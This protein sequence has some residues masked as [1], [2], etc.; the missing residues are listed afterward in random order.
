M[1]Q[2]G[3]D[4]FFNIQLQCKLCTTNTMRN[5]KRL[6][7]KQLISTR[8][9]LKYIH[10]LKEASA[11]GGE[12]AASICKRRRVANKGRITPQSFKDNLIFD[13]SPTLGKKDINERESRERERRSGSGSSE[14]EFI[15]G[16]LFA[17]CRKIAFAG[18]PLMRLYR[19]DGDSL[20]SL[21]PHYGERPHVLRRTA[22]DPSSSS[23]THS[24]R[25]PALPA[26]STFARFAARRIPFSSRETRVCVSVNSFFLYFVSPRSNAH[27]VFHRMPRREIHFASREIPT[28]RQTLDI[29]PYMV[30]IALA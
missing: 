25:V 19:R 17:A 5:K 4:V 16:E 27:R 30:R 2:N 1:K 29:H 14:R 24:S 12:H 15:R 8:A 3:K 22:N 26:N 7:K 13:C 23:T 18:M 9:T 21:M 28:I 10:F 6:S 11:R 20:N